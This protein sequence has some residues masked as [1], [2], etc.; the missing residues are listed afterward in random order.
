MLTI[1]L[2]SFTCKLYTYNFAMV[3]ILKLRRPQKAGTRRRWPAFAGSAMI[4]ATIG[5]LALSPG[6]PA[7]TVTPAIA[8]KYSVRLVHHQ[9]PRE[10]WATASPDASQPDAEHQA[11]QIKPQRRAK[12]SRKSGPAAPQPIIAGEPRRFQLPPDLRRPTATQT[13]VQ[14]DVPPDVVLKQEI[15]L[16]TALLWTQTI[17]PPQPVRQFVAPPA[18]KPP[19]VS[20]NLPASP[21]LDPPNRETDV[22]NLN[23]AAAAVTETPHLTHPAT[24]ASPVSSPAP[25]P[26]REIPQVGL[27]A[28][29]Q[30][31]ASG[32]IS[33]SNT[34]LNP[35]PVAVLPP[36][37]QIAASDRA[38]G[39]S[40]PDSG[41]NTPQGSSSLGS[42]AQSQVQKTTRAQ[43]IAV[44]A[45]GSTGTVPAPAAGAKGKGSARPS[46]NNATGRSRTTA[47][48]PRE[49]ATAGNRS[50]NA[51]APAL[52]QR[53]GG[54]EPGTAGKADPPERAPLNIPGTTHITQPRDG[55]F[56]VVVQGS[57]DSARYPESSGA[58]SGKVVYT[59]Y[60]RVGMRK[61]WILQ[62][63]LP[64][65][66]GQAS[67]TPVDAPWPFEMLRPDRLGDSDSDYVM[68]K[69]MLT[70]GGQFEQLAMVFPDNMETRDLLL[71]SLKSWA[72][73]PA[74]RDGEPTA[75]EVLLIIPKQME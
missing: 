59:V 65:S 43:E 38:S 16:P 57:A 3:L 50:G 20:K 31:S 53:H 56:G 40:S 23:V 42:A 68:V 18:S 11:E 52:E 55:K 5:L 71:A 37:N 19:E 9:M 45:K 34:P 54:A 15:P 73:R 32:L 47:P 63:C 61:N 70:S 36:A 74:S 2:R 69:G 14:I 1:S 66:A 27:A 4:H 58:L 17:P 30:P 24:I 41:S 21:V 25:E 62:Y 6:K 46:T 10:D 49:V 72:F 29:T 75:V 8:S 13:L 44:H 33:I 26:A 51:P 12:R 64:K 67:S 39:L 22:A 48:A 60:L 28:S 35:T 7:V